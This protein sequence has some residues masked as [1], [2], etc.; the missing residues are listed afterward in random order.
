MLGERAT[1]GLEGARD[2][3]AAFL[4]ARE[5]REVIFVR[6][7]TEGLNLVAY[8]WGLNNLGPGDAVVVTEL[9]HHSVFVPFQYIARRQGA[10]FVMLPLDDNDEV[11]Y[12]G[13]DEIARNHNVKIVATNLVSNSLGTIADIAAARPLGARAGRDLRLRRRAGRTASP[14]GRAGARRRLPRRSRATRCAR[15]AGSARCGAAPSCWRRWSRS[16]SAGT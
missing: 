12:S 14:R 6:N 3:V 2:K 8:S 9:E 7:A 13:L 4:N 1:A 16:S 10:E 5:S 11:D 15:R